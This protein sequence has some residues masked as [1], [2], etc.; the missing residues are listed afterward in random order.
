MKI[1][2]IYS[3]I[4]LAAVLGL[5]ACEKESSFL[6]N[7]GEGQLNC[8]TLS[9][10][11]INSG[12]E[13]RAGGVNV[14]DFDVNFVKVENGVETTVKSYSYGEMP[15]VVSLPK[16]NYKA[17]ASYGDNPIAAWES[18]YYLGNTSFVIKEG[19]ITNDVDPVECQLSNIRISVNIDDLGLG[20][21]GPD[22]KVVVTA[23]NEGMLT[24]TE[25]TNH[26]PGYFRYINGSQTIVASFSGTVDGVYVD[27]VRRYYDNAN[28][29]NAYGVTFTVTKP[30]NVEP[31]NINITDGGI[32]IDATITVVDQ[33]Q[34]VKPGEQEEILED[35]MRPEEEPQI[36]EN[37]ENPDDPGTEPDPGT[38]PE[39]V[40]KGPKI[41]ATAPGLKLNQR[42]ELVSSEATPVSFKV[43]SETGISEFKIIIE[44]NKLT[45]DEL[46]GVGLTDELDLINPGTYA[47]ALTG[48][49][50][51]NG[52]EVLGKKECSFDISN[53]VPLLMALGTGE[54]KFII[55][56]GDSEGTTTDT[57]WLFYTEP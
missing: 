31:G 5:T 10:D 29:G 3:T 38:D 48:L 1:N 42:Y 14:N 25:S 56:V 27:N 50:F 17:V 7:E 40:V 13:V 33:N 34:V 23:G 22:V 15:Q 6:F 49:G 12:R 54:H 51:K 46:K 55:T 20:L 57:L 41:I 26:T 9:V 28:A 39:P 53:F 36:P 43:T 35:D 19:E 44:S 18:P 52:D 11:Y 30:D 2:K 45:P 47:E 21:L 24:Y 37:P 32:Q 8:E 4:A 16:G